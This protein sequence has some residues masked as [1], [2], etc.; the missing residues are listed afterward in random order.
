MVTNTFHSYNACRYMC[1][2][3]NNGTL[4]QPLNKNVTK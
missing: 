2:V 4:A 3:N 1:A